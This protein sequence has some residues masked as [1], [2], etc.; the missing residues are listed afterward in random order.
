V[1]LQVLEGLTE[2]G[3]G[4]VEGAV[5]R[6]DVMEVKVEMSSVRTGTVSRESHDM[7]ARNRKIKNLFPMVWVATVR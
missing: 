3:W 1:R 7:A 5:G 6:R 4:H 2:T